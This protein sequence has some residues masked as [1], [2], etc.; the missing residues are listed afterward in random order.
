M[1]AFGRKQIGSLKPEYRMSN[2]EFR[3]MKLKK[4]RFPPSAFFIP[5]ST[6]CGS[7]LNLSLWS[8]EIAGCDLN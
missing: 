6:F 7:F 1:H 3:M 4:L 8:R 2:K 5:C